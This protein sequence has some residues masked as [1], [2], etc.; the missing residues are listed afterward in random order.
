MADLEHFELSWRQVRELAVESEHRDPLR[1]ANSMGSQCIVMPD[2]QALMT[3]KKTRDDMLC[4]SV[5]AGVERSRESHLVLDFKSLIY[6]L[7]GNM[8]T[9]CSGMNF[10]MTLKHTEC[11]TAEEHRR[12]FKSDNLEK[13][14]QAEHWLLHMT[15]DV[16]AMFQY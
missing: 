15:L 9:S 16:E 11:A 6:H 2:P 12:D 5:E 1:N 8:A 13:Q 10:D 7:V 4:S 14:V 3:K